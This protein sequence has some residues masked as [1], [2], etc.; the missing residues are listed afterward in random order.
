MSEVLG[1]LEYVVE[2]LVESEVVNLLECDVLS[3]RAYEV[4]PDS[5]ALLASVDLLGNVLQE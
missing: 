2:I 3:L 5:S 1:S 4:R